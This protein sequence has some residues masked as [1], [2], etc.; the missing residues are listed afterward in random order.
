MKTHMLCLTWLLVDTYLG[1]WYL[2]KIT[3]VLRP[4]ALASDR[5][6]FWLIPDITERQQ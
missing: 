3:D 5:I 2:K 4:V 6:Q 1:T